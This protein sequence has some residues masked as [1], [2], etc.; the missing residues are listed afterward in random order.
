LRIPAD[1]FHCFDEI[2]G[3]S[4]T[5]HWPLVQGAESVVF[6]S[7]RGLIAVAANNQKR[8]SNKGRVELSGD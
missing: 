4:Y 1:R 7:V 8:D 6:I 2:T 3:L 5:G